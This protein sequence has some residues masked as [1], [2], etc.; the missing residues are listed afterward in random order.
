MAL[1]TRDCARLTGQTLQTME[2]FRPLR[3]I[4]NRAREFARASITASGL[5]WMSRY[6]YRYPTLM[7]MNL[8]ARQPATRDWPLYRLPPPHFLIGYQY[9]VR[10]CND[11][12]FESR[13]YSRLVYRETV[14]LDQQIMDWSTLANCTYTVNAGAYHRFVDL[15]NFAETLRQVQQAVL[16]ERVVADL[17]LIRPMRGFGRTDM[18]DA[19]RVPVERLLQEQCMDL[20]ACQDQAWGFAERIRIQQAGRRDLLVLTT[21]RRLRS[22]YFN[23]LLSLRP[24]V[25]DPDP[26]AAGPSSRAPLSP[27]PEPPLS[28]PCDCDWLDA[29]LERFSDPVQ[30]E[31]VRAETAESTQRTISHVIDAL[32]LPHRAPPGG[33]GL[34]GLAGGAFELR[35][36]ENGRA[37]TEEMRRRRGEVVRR[38]ID[39][40]P[41]PTRRR[42][43]ARPAPP[44]PSPP[45]PSPGPEPEE[46]E[47][48]PAPEP[49]R[50]F[51]EEVRAAIAE[52]IRLLQ[53][54]L[55][56]SARNEQFFNFAVDFYEAL[57]ALERD[58]NINESTVRRWVIYFFVV[59]HVAT[60]LNYLHHRLRLQRVF[61][62]Y[63]E[64]NLAQ[65]V[66]RAR[67]DDG[68]VIYSRV[69]N[70]PGVDAFSRLMRRIS[71][72]LA[73]TVGRAGRGE[74]DEEEIERFMSD[75]AYREHSGDVDEIL[76]QAA[77]NDAAIQSVDLSFRFKMTGPVAFTQNPQ[78][79]DVNRRVVQ[80]ASDLNF[81]FQPLPELNDPVPLPPE[82]PPRARPPLGPR[83]VL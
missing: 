2:L 28:L 19:R 70:E 61:S 23:F 3:N 46:E 76:R 82:R 51:A 56:V 14:R 75:I 44:S 27:A 8:G 4:W 20:G 42:R 31:T 18:A 81:R 29:F 41:L 38:F 77:L 69:W 79:Q 37:V 74:L 6:V 65:I 25:A 35:P 39:S 64:L 68:A 26:D 15:D 32:S 54:E 73:A 83:R 12:V 80:H 13:A 9:L 57:A 78:I 55:T 24:P 72:D 17:A 53:D 34:A 52:A 59:E 11:Y 71:V 36:R 5:A 67:D 40:L 1:S 60:T 7:L 33:L 66:M 10:V 49:A 21:I 22:A 63:V 48:E 43:V 47:E 58:D 16:A 45:P 62:R 30:A 50:A